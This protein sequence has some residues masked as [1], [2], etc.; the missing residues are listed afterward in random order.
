MD[1]LTA[2]AIV[3]GVLIA[4]WV[5]VGGTI[6]VFWFIGVIGWACFSAA[7]GKMNGLKK[8][9]PAGVVG[10]TLAAAAELVSMLSG[11]PELEWV[12]L[13]VGAFIIVIGSKLPLLSFFPAGLCGLTVVGAGGVMGIMDL[14]TNVKLGI[15]FVAGTVL[16]YIAEM[17]A[18]MV[19]KKA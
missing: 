12:A 7:G 17:A 18:G 4:L 19:A 14:A 15:A 10:M 9:I 5:K 8:A 2:L 6:G 11:H 1:M 16:G 3:V 13:G